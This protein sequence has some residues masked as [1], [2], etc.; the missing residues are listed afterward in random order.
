V[1]RKRLAAV[2]V[3]YKTPELSLG[4]LDSLLPQVDPEIDEVLLVDNGSQDDSVSILEAGLRERSLPS[5]FRIV[6]PPENHGFSAGVNVGLK[7]ADAEYYLVLNSDILVGE[8]AVDALLEYAKSTKQVGVIGPRLEGLDGKQQIST[9]RYPSA[10]GELVEAAGTG[11]ITRLLTPAQGERAESL[12]AGRLWISFAAVLLSRQIIE[13]IGLMDE[14]FFM[15]FEDVD[16]CRRARDAGFR[17]VSCPEARIIHL[18]GGSSPVKQL[19]AERKQLPSYYYD[20]RSRYFTKHHGRGF[21]LLA[22]CLWTLGQ[23]IAWSREL[24]GRP[25]HN[26]R[27]AAIDIWRGATKPLRS[28]QS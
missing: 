24:I 2:I 18:R 26:A 27:R 4:A 8:G 1:D 17:L 5:S 11:P 12:E 21:L 16:Y 22:N 28:T 25:R 13:Q 23:T 19:R 6:A 3:N 20:S 14:D 7:A 10:R 15:F 9:F